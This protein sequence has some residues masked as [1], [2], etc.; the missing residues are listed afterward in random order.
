MVQQA[1]GEQV[2]Q[3]RVTKQRTVRILTVLAALVV[4]ILI[5]EAFLFAFHHVPPKQSNGLWDAFPENS[6]FTR[7][8]LDEGY[9]YYPVRNG[10]FGTFSVIEDKPRILVLGDSY[11]QGLEMMPEDNYVSLLSERFPGINFINAGIPGTAVPEQ[12]VFYDRYEELNPQYYFLQIN[13]DDFTSN[14]YQSWNHYRFEYNGSLHVVR[15]HEKA[16]FT[17]NIRRVQGLGW[18]FDHSQ[19]LRIIIGRTAA[20][21]K[22]QPPAYDELREDY[23][24]D[25][26]MALLHN[27]YGDRIAIIYVPN[28]PRI[29]RNGLYIVDEQNAWR[30]ELR[31]AAQRNNIPIIDLTEPFIEYY[32]RT[33][34]FPFGFSNTQPGTGHWNKAGNQIAA[35]Q[36]ALFI[37]EQDIAE[38]AQ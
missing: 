35:E 4:A 27:R 20:F 6:T 21:F 2:A 38:S 32:N 34:Q 25:E 10:M 5:W 23:Y 36:I 19:V 31:T 30:E 33:G 22:P 16:Y 37:E 17:D 14:P 13:S 15:K 11:T 12:I 3:S 8:V 24:V 29:D 7:F 9:S 18:L 28:I 26:Q 1:P